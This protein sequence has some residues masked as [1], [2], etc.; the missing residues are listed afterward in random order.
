[1]IMQEFPATSAATLLFYSFKPTYQFPSPH[2][3]SNGQP[4][5]APPLAKDPTLD[6]GARTQY[7][8]QSPGVVFSGNPG[9]LV[10]AP[11]SGLVVFAGEWSSYR[12]LILID[13]C[14]FHAILVGA[15]P[16]FVS[17]GQYVHAGD[18]I[19]RIDQEESDETRIYL[20]FRRGGTP[21]DPSPYWQRK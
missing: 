2:C 14:D 12:E 8:A 9:T 16:V 1:M 7:G 5:L 20:E 6:F 4:V 13:A 10:R 18:V 15:S 17:R 11:V 19:A 3:Q 21:I